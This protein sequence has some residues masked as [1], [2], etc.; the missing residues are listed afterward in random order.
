M[1]S[2]KPNKVCATQCKGIE[3]RQFVYLRG[4]AAALLKVDSN[5][6]CYQ[7]VL[8]KTTDTRLQT[9]P[10]HSQEQAVNSICNA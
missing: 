10:C 6:M 3:D 2:H 5:V 8:I 9:A 7:R 1:K 4:F